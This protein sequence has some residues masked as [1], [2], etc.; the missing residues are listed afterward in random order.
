MAPST[1]IDVRFPMLLSE[2]ETLIHAKHNKVLTNS[3][4]VESL[5]SQNLLPVTTKNTAS[6][7]RDPS[8]LLDSL[9]YLSD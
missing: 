1:A 2:H 5:E 4:P 9:R 6:L 7:I 8:G 3:I